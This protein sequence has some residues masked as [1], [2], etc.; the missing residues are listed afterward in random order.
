MRKESDTKT[1]PFRICTSPA[2]TVRTEPSSIVSSTPPSSR[3]STDATPSTEAI[4]WKAVTS[5]VASC[6]CAEFAK[7]CNSKTD[8]AAMSA[9]REVRPPQPADFYGADPQVTFYCESQRATDHSRVRHAQL[10]QQTGSQ[11][12]TSWGWSSADAGPAGL[13]AVRQAPPMAP[14]SSRSRPRSRSRSFPVG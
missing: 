10:N 7:K 3:V 11:A 12:A 13:R 6:A 4:S 1:V 14:V 9:D 2:G 5:P 8:A